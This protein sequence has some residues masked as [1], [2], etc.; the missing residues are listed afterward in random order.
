MKP[1][2]FEA[3]PEVAPLRQA[4]LQIARALGLLERGLPELGLTHSQAHALSELER[5]GELTAGELAAL[6]GLDKSTASR[7]VAQLAEQGYVAGGA[8]GS[9]RDRRRKPL[10][11]TAKGRTKV[12]ALH[13]RSDRQAH[14]ALSLLSV[15]ERQAARQG[16]TL[17][18]RALSRLE[19]RRGYEVRPITRRDDPAVA[20]IIR[21]V[22]TEFGASGP[23]FAI[24][25][26]EV[27]AMY[28]AYRP[29]HAGY[30]VIDTGGRV[31]GGGGFGPLA[32]DEQGVC[33][34]RKM[35]FL[36]ETRGLGLGQLLLE[37]VQNAAAAAGY[38]TMYL[39]TLASMARARQLYE[40][41]GFQRL[42]KSIGATGHFGCDAWYAKR[43]DG[44]VE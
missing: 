35:Y 13:A 11:L 27:D 8:G 7:A 6:L 9:G 26:P 2:P 29:P 22:M 30:F 37:R 15:A 43:L 41:A 17:Y 18:A 21:V 28:G 44:A 36:P 3:H 12:A 4:S 24:H 42:S 1:K 10:R 34:L 25:D 23:G 19:R 33:E 5:A 14:E 39:E 40:A 32:G 16:V 20:A 31:V 38:H